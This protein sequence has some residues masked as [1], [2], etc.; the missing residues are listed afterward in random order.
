MKGGNRMN[1]QVTKSYGIGKLSVKKQ[2]LIAIGAI[3]AAVVLPQLFHVVGMVS[4][5]GTALGET[6]LPMHLPILLAGLIAGPYAGAIAGLL[7]P[8]VSFGLT[9][10]PGPAMLPFM[11]IELCMYGLFAGLLQN[12]KMPTIAKVLLAQI[13]GRAVRAVAILVSVYLLGNAAIHTAVIWN[14]IIAG[15]PG[16]ILQWTLLPLLV[17]RIERGG[18]YETGAHE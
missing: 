1:N 6:F 8:L 14:S 11:M 7:S 12:T 16:L 3:A 15:I 18:N 13:G 17:Y 4:N 9:A 5:M 10:M 2:V